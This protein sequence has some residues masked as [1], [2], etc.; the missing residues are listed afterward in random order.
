MNK[1]VYAIDLDWTI[2]L[3]QFRG[4][5]EP[6]PIQ[7]RIDYI[8]WLYKKWHII[9]IYTARDP[10]L[11]VQTYAWLVKHWVMHHWINMQRKPGSDYYLDDKAIY[12]NHFFNDK[13]NDL[14]FYE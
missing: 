7:S 14:N 3:G 10:S 9:L 8:N 4:E 13:I 2:C 12:T 6:E 11:F 5:W 1:L